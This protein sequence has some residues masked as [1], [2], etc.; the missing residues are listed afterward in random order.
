MLDESTLTRPTR[1]A[2][3]ASSAS[4]TDGFACGVRAVRDGIAFRARY[5][6][7]GEAVS[8]APG[9]LAHFLIERYCLYTADGGRVYR[10]ELHHRPWRLQQA[11]GELREM[12]IS[13]VAL[14]GPPNLLYA[15]SQDVLIWPLEEL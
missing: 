3:R 11:E 8:A 9:T 10:A 13:P 5:A 14:E 12:T 7:D 15:A 6:G 1:A 4:G 2:L